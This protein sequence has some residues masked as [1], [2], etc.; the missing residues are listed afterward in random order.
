MAQESK[1]PLSDAISET[2]GLAAILREAR[3]Q[4]KA[5]REKG[6]WM[7][8]P[9]CGRRIVKKEFDKKGCY[10][11]GWEEGENKKQALPYKTH[12]SGCGREVIT[13]ELKNKGCF[14]CGWKEGTE[15]RS[16]KSENRGEMTENAD[17]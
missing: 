2:F 10:A 7:L 15:V 12:C 8:C 3:K 5:D 17:L 11:C 1:E 14:V 6:Y 4:D 13:G 9:C 16:Q